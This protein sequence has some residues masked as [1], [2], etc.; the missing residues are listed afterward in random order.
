MHGRVV[1]IYRHPVKG[2]TPERLE[3]AVLTAGGYFP[4]DRLYA[5]EN[6]PS[7]FDPAAP[8]FTPKSRFTVLASIA[9][10]ARARTAYDEAT[11]VLTATA[12]RSAPFS[13]D[14]TTEIGRAAFA[15]WLT[16]FLGPD[17]LRGPL[18]VLQAPGHRFTDSPSGY[19][20]LVNLESVRDLASRMGRAVDPLRFRANLY[21]D[22]PPAWS[23]LDWARGAAARIGGAGF[24]VGK[25]IVRCAATHVDPETGERDMEIVAALRDLYGHLYCGVYLSVAAGGQIRAGDALE[26]L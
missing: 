7:G 18:Q 3:S 21:V 9:D 10:V 8:D 24:E 19:V 22:G 25:P 11:G 2:F 4:G 17:T 16:A 5:V 1:S 14:L 20:S 15:A 13:G 23:E 6:G 26:R 12:P